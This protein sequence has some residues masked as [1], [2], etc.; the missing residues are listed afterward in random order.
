MSAPESDFTGASSSGAADPAFI[1]HVA[2]NVT[3]ALWGLRSRFEDGGLSDSLCRCLLAHTAC[4][5]YFREGVRLIKWLL[6][7][8]NCC[9]DSADHSATK[10]SSMPC[11]TALCTED[12]LRLVFCA[13]SLANLNRRIRKPN[14]FSDHP[15]SAARQLIRF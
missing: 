4:D 14:A 2:K 13:S 10:N 12:K 11:T 3:Q 6:S 5:W 1:V 15:R 7:T 9:C 8:R